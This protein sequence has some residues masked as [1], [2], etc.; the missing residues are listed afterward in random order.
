LLIHGT[1]DSICPPF[2]AEELFA[3]APQDKQLLW[4]P[5][6]DH[7][8]GFQVGGQTY[9][10]TISQVIERWTGFSSRSQP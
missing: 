9:R 10:N 5:E 4:I 8:N 7:N 2:M 1:A 3:R 6:A